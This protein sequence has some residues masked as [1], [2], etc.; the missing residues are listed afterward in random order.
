[1]ALALGYRLLSSALMR[2]GDMRAGVKLGGSTFFI[3]VKEQKKPNLIPAGRDSS[4]H[5]NQHRSEY[6]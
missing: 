6:E 4:E 3:E 5:A 1:V 2:K